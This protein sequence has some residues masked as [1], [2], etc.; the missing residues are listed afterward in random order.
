MPHTGGDVQDSDRYLS[1]SDK[2]N[3]KGMLSAGVTPFA[4]YLERELGT[5]VAVY[6]S[7]MEMDAP[8]IDQSDTD[9]VSP[10]LGDLTDRSRR[11]EQQRFISDERTIMVATKGFGMGIDKPNIRR[12]IHRTPPSNLEAYTRKRAALGVTVRSPTRFCTIH[13]KIRST[14]IRVHV[15]SMTTRSRNSS[16]TGKYIRRED[17]MVM[18]AFLGTVSRKIGDSLYFANDE[19]IAFFERCTS[20]PISATAGGDKV[21]FTWP[22]FQPRRPILKERVFRA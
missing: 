4:S 10:P 15:R 3:A 14:T 20:T 16:S 12:V 13:P 9:E 22:S 1:E 8:L 2:Q 19:A 7:K 17:I 6:H 11:L 18:R 5:K 21:L